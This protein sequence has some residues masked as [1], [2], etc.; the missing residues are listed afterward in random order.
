MGPGGNGDLEEEER[1][2]WTKV[3]MSIKS[4]QAAASTTENDWRTDIVE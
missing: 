2:V 1:V 4:A 3:K